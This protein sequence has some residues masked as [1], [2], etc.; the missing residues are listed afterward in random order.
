MK[1][2]VF[3]SSSGIIDDVYFNEAK[4]LGAQITKNNFSLVYGGANVGLMG[5]LAEAVKNSQGHVHGIIPKRIQEKGLAYN[6][7]DILEITDSMHERKSRMEAASG[8]FIALP[9]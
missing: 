4:A 8:A 2:C 1:I 6:G 9:G 3:C 5:T 7:A